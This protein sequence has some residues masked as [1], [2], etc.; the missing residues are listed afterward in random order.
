[1][2]IVIAMLAVVLVCGAAYAEDEAATL[3][4]SNPAAVS[5]SLTVVDVGNAICPVSGQP[6]S[7]NDFYTYHD[8]RYG[9]CC[10][11][12]KEAFEKEPAKYAAIADKETAE[13]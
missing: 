7:G 10:P 9:L 1:M 11:L 2:K 3:S 8:R 4:E 5:E 6:V 13:K 12:C